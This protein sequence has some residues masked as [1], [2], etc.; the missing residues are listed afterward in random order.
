ME[1]AE[2]A[3]RAREATGEISVAPLIGKH[4]AATAAVKDV[5]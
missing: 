3:Y 2:T 4:A 5:E 1:L